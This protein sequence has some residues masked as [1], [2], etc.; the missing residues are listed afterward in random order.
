MYVSTISLGSLKYHVF[1]KFDHQD[2][3]IDDLIPCQMP[4]LNFNIKSLTYKD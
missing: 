3:G 2:T 4:E 1:I